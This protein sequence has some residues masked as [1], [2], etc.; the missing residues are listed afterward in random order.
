MMVICHY[1]HHPMVLTIMMV[2]VRRPS[3]AQTRPPELSRGPFCAM[4]R[5]ER[6]YGNED[7]A[8]APEGSFW[9]VVRARGGG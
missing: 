2:M 3:F 6:E 1:R 8:G 5:A 9:A 4:F 7:L